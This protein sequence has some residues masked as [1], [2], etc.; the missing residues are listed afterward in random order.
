VALNWSDATTYAGILQLYRDLIQLR[1]DWHN[2]TRGLRGDGLN[3]FHINDSDKFIAFH[4]WSEGGPLDDVVVAL[5]FANRAY[6]SY[7]IGL[8]RVGQWRVRFNSDWAGYDPEFGS[9]LGY[10]TETHEGG[11][12]GMP[13]AANIGIGPYTALILS[14]DS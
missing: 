2:T 8:P 1:R 13:A 4:R 9:W 11:R 12:D 14:Q 5:N 10:D 6:T 7:T 3:V